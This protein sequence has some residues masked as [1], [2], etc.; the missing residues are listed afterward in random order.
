[1]LVEVLRKV[2]TGLIYNRIKVTI[3][4]HQAFSDLQF[5]F[6]AKRST[7]E[8]SLQFTAAMEQAAET[9][10]EIAGSTWDIVRAFDSVAKPVLYLAAVRLGIPADW[11]K[12]LISIDADSHHIVRTPWAEHCLRHCGREYFRAHHPSSP[13]PLPR[14]THFH[15]VRGVGQGD[16]GSPTLW[17]MVM[18]ILLCALDRLTTSP[19]HLLT[20]TGHLL[21]LRDSAYA[22]DLLSFAS[23][24]AGL[25]AK[26]DLV[27]AFCIVGEYCIWAIFIQALIYANALKVMT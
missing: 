21:R 11:A 20:A 23:S 19:F 16:V 3:E 18:D 7:A 2:W 26:A 22:D 15:A 12:Y 1:M 5:G 14:P 10:A 13:S 27:S 24:L 8:P 6:R 25:Q 4:K 17:N 9:G